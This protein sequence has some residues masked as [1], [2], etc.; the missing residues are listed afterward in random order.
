M[1]RW[2]L[3]APMFCWVGCAGGG[4]KGSQYDLG[5]YH[6]NHNENEKATDAFQRS[7]LIDASDPTP[8]EAL[9]QAYFERGWRAKAIQEWELVLENSSTD[10]AFYQQEGKPQRSAAWINDG[11]AAH[12]RAITALITAY[13]AQGEESVGKVLWPDAAV[14]FKRITE[15][16]PENASAWTSYGKAAK[17]SKDANGYY[18]AFKKLAKLQPK[19]ADVQ[20]DLGYAAFGLEKL[21]EAEA[22]F[23]KYTQLKPE[24]PKGYNNLGTLLAQTDRNASAIKAFD[25]ALEL[26]PGMPQALNGQGTAH[27]NQKEY[28]HARALWAKVLEQDPDDA[29]AKENIRTLTQMG[30]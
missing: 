9:A 30:Y 27:F 28:D 13:T 11:I 22:A 26:Q 3:I 21:G 18:A 19:E 29:V 12:K 15:L 20:K 10:P 5:L 7:V 1:K 16:D 24:D 14:A 17:K 23:R 25:K 4:T 2:I 8:R 6:K